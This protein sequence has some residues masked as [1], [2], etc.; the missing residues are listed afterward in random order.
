MGIKEVL[1]GLGYGVN[2]GGIGLKERR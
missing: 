1:I 2:R